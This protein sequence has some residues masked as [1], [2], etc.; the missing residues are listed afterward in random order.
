MSI[1]SKIGDVAK[2]IGGVASANSGSL[3]EGAIGIGTGALNYISSAKAAKQ[4]FEYSLALQNHQNLFTQNMSNTAHQREVADLRAAGLNPILSAT[5]GSGASTPTSGSASQSPVDPN[6][7]EAI[8]TALDYKRYKNE[9][10][11]KDSTKNV[12]DS[13]VSLNK[14][15]GDK[16]IY[17]GDL[18]HYNSAISRENLRLLQEYGDDFKKLELLKFKS[19][20]TNNNATTAATLRRIDAEIAQIKSNTKYLDS[21]ANYQDISA[22]LVGKKL[23]WYDIENYAK[24]LGLTVGAFISTFGLKQVAGGKYIKQASNLVKV[25]PKIIPASKLGF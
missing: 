21:S 23:D 20:I 4:S 18:A 24:A 15:L 3:L 8:A 17:E 14:T 7:G 19:D 12:N 25:S 1:W 10:D 13:Q 22:E 2:K 9:R 16:A 6:L 11:L 5:G